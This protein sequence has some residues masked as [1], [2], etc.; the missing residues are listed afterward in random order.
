MV[1]LGQDLARR[2]ALQ[3]HSPQESTADCHE[4]RGRYAL[5]R[6]ITDREPQTHA[7]KKEEVVEISTDLPGRSHAGGDFEFVSAGNDFR[8]NGLLQ[9][10]S[11]SQLMFEY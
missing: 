8:Q 4:K 2:T 6:N 5:A 10:R 1:H 3:S 11:D 7:V 9:L